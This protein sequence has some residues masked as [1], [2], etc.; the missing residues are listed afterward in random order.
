MTYT[1]SGM[2]EIQGSLTLVFCLEGLILVFS[3]KEIST[4]AKWMLPVSCFLLL[5][6]KYPYALMFL[7]SLTAYYSILNYK[8]IPKLIIF[9]FHWFWNPKNRRPILFFLPIP[10]IILIL[11]IGN[12]LP[13]NSK[14]LLLLF[15]LTILLFTIDISHFIYKKSTN[16]QS[17]FFK[18]P[19]LWFAVYLPSLF[20]ILIHPDRFRS[21]F[22]TIQHKQGGSNFLLYFE[23]ILK[24]LSIPFYFWILILGFFIYVTYLFRMDV[25]KKRFSVYLTISFWILIGQIL[26]TSNHQER[27]IYHIYPAL[28]LVVIYFI[29]EF[30]NLILSKF[31][32]NKL[33]LFLYS[34]IVFILILFAVVGNFSLLENLSPKCYVEN[35]S[36]VSYIPRWTEKWADSFINSPTL[37]INDLNPNH[38]NR[39]DV[40]LIL[41]LSAYRNNIP[42]L[43]QPKR[44]IDPVAWNTVVRVSNECSKSVTKDFLEKKIESDFTLAIV[45]EETLS[46]TNENPSACL[47]KYKIHY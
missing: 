1:Y 45:Q 39:P 46:S 5:Q 10:I 30:Y 47:E 16:L 27:H 41:E 40:Q 43:I 21:L 33:I 34:G 20:W 36:D 29:E 15:Q 32:H 11:G 17:V 13:K 31:S 9:Y 3:T 4:N 38:I 42:I 23:T 6:T 24:D 18:L 28:I 12:F 44:K 19:F 8:E 26:S 2:L 22:S 7:F 25:W 37:I 35:K 14:I